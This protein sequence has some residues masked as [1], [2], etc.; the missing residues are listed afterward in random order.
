MDPLVA[1]RCRDAVR[2]E[3]G[4]DGIARCAAS[5]DAALDVRARHLS[6]RACLRPIDLGLHAGVPAGSIQHRRR[7]PLPQHLWPTAFARAAGA[8]APPRVSEEEALRASGPDAVYLGALR[9]RKPGASLS[10]VRAR[11]SGFRSKIGLMSVGIDER[12]N[13]AGQPALT[14][15]L[16]VFC[17]ERCRHRAEGRGQ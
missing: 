3:I 7:K 14:G 4:R 5:F 10:S 9:T 17:S 12:M 11:S 15:P 6:L 16:T 13:L 1:I 8:P 2:V